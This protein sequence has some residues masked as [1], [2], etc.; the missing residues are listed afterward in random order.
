MRHYAAQFFDPLK[1]VWLE[2]LEQPTKAS[3]DAIAAWPNVTARVVFYDKIWQPLD[4]KPA[5]SSA[6][7]RLT[8]KI[9]ADKSTIYTL[10]AALLE[11]AGNLESGAVEEANVCAELAR[12]LNNELS[13]W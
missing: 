5:K 12:K 2:P 6:S 10:V 4:E 9:D 13:A 3:A 8:V 11:Y 1:N 7:S